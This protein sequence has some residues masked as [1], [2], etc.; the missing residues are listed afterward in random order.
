M[1][2]ITL[3]FAAG[4]LTGVILFGGTATY[5]AS[6]IAERSANRIFVDGREAQMEAYTINGN[7]YVRLRDIDR[8]VGFSV[9]WDG[10]VQIST[11]ASYS[12]ETPVELATGAVSETYSREVYRA[13][14]Q[15]VGGAEHSD[16]IPVTETGY[17]AMQSATAAISGYPGYDV[18]WE[19]DGTAYFTQ[20]YSSVY[21][22]AAAYCQPFIDGLKGLPDRDK[23]QEIACFVCD[24]LTYEASKSPTPRVVLTSNSRNLIT[25]GRN[26]KD[27]IL[28][29]VTKLWAGDFQL[30]YDHP[31]G[32]RH[33]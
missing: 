31:E 17:S 1:K 29:C 24:W 20:S 18:R 16:P 8:E 19:A 27:S 10:T 32:N 5:A 22:E 14:L 2:R 6:V 3:S 4:L 9:T 12:V 13:L 33:L 23:A 30:S 11:T 7:N 25:C 21:A 28:N 26:W 15:V